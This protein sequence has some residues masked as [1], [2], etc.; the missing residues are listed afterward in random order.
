MKTAASTAVITGVIEAGFAAYDIW[1]LEK[2]EF[3]NEHDYN[4]EA[5]KRVGEAIGATTGSVAGGLIGQALIP[6]P[7]VGFLLGSL[8]G[9]ISGRWLASTVSGRVV[10]GVVERK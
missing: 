8:L 9:N 10:D 1:K 3:I 6:I 7:I 5:T 4:R 2:D